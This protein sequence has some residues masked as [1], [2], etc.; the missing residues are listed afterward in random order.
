MSCSALASLP[1]SGTAISVN[2]IRIPRDLIANEIQHHPAASPLEAWREAALALIVRELLRQEA[3]RQ[4]IV[5]EP[6]C[7]E[8][9]RRETPEEASIR[10]LLERNVKAPVPDD[11]VC[12]RYYENNKARFR[13]PALF[14]AAHIL[15]AADPA[16]KAARAAAKAEASRLIAL[17]RERPEHFGDLARTYSAC[18]SRDLDGNLGQ[19]GPGQTVPEFEAALETLQMGDIAAEPIGSRYGFHV[20]R[21]DRRIDGRALPFDLVKTQI[22]DYLAEA[23]QHRAMA[24]YVSILIG[25]ASIKGFD[26]AGASSPLVQ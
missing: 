11:D 25:G 4:G 20:I 12:R 17:L 8:A 6:V 26:I 15:I 9:G 24:Q 13:T 5:C 22:A 23:S 10:G 3:D 18:P 21:L 16:D 1:R 19:I 7:D 2:G 14:E